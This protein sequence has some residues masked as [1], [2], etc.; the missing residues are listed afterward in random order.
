MMW[1]R[2]EGGISLEG[3]GG[4]VK[5]H[6]IVVEGPLGVGKTSLAELLSMRLNARPLLEEAEENPFLSD[7]YRNP[8]EYRFQTQMYF[9]LSR[10]RQASN[11]GQRGL[12]EQ[13]VVSDCLFNKDRLFAKI[14]L[15]DHE[16]RLYD[17]VF[18]MLR[19]RVPTPDLVIFLQARTEVLMERIRRRGR[20]F[21]RDISYSYLEA[22]NQSFNDFFFHYADSPLLVVN[23]SEIDFVHHPADLEDLMVQ[24]GKLKA[25]IQYYVPVASAGGGI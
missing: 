21:E 25:G 14:N 6:Y 4:V 15:D 10:Y 7:F 2:P 18:E 5:H 17:Q 9:L 3:V 23:A 12:F 19:S 20:K 1:G 8:K 22:I 13:A 11:M 24:V 16:F